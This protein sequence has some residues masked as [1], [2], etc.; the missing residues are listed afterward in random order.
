VN[1]VYFKNIEKIIAA[2]AAMIFSMFLISHGV[3]TGK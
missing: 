2:E 1:G 3:I